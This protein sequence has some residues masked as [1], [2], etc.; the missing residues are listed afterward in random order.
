M[1]FIYIN[2]HSNLNQ[3]QQDY[4]LKVLHKLVI[5]HTVY[6]NTVESVFCKN[7]G[8]RKWFSKK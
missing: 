5:F 7:T 1:K 3:Y 2:W 8:K 4:I 6:F